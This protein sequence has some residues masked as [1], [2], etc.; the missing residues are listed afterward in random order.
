MSSHSNLAWIGSVI[1][2]I[3]SYFENYIQ[4]KDPSI[5]LSYLVEKNSIV[6]NLLNGGTTECYQRSPL[7]TEVELSVSVFSDALKVDENGQLG[8]VC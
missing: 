4:K 2:P 1:S 3:C 8:S 6:R 5:K 7:N